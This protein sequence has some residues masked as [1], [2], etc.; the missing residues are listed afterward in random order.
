VFNFT[1][2]PSAG[3]TFPANI[4]LSVSGLPEGATY[5]F[6]PTILAAGSG[7]TQVTLTINLPQTQAASVRHTNIPMAANH[8]NAPLG[9]V[10]GRMAPFALALILL[11]FAGRLRRA[12][13]RM[14]RMLSILLFAVAG[15]AVVS[16]ISGCG[17]TSGF[18]AQQQQTYTLT[19]TGTAG[20]LSHSATVTLIVE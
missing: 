16:A 3:T 19:I 10:A 6:S 14:N 15:M 18:F 20:S 11:P 17:S 13:R 7:A 2:T 8:Q 4:V 1:A 12:G 9:Y 5:T